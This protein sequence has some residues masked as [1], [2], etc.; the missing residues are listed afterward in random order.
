MSAAIS[1]TTFFSSGPISFSA[2][3]AAFKEVSDG[4]I[5][6]SELRR[7]TDVSNTDPIVPD[8][9]ENNNVSTS[10]DLRLSSF[11]NT[12]KRYNVVQTGTDTGLGNVRNLNWN[13]NGRRNIIKRFI[14]QGTIGTTN[15][16]SPALLFEGTGFNYR[17]EVQGS[18]LGA[19]GAGGTSGSSNG[20][21]GGN[22]IQVVNTNPEMDLPSVTYYHRVI[23]QNGCAVYA[24]GGGGS[25]GQDGGQGTS[26]TC[27]SITEYITER[28]CGSCPGC[29]PG[30]TRISCFN[31][32]GCQ[33][34][35]GGCR[36]RW[37]RAVCQKS[38]PYSVPGAPGGGG[39]TG[40]R[41]QGYNQ[42]RE[43]GFG[44]AA[45][46]PGGCPSY[47]GSG[48][49]GET[50]GNGGDWAITGSTTSRPVGAGQPGRAVTGSR[51]TVEGVINTNTI[52]G[53]Y[54]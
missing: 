14:V 25:Q 18:I 32:G 2:L 46:T 37:E 53:A 15:T 50:G 22:A 54:T 30:D 49:T 33:C 35:K 41:G 9:T 44:G 26:G 7:N 23:L 20:K 51:Y 47:G 28:Q 4:Q 19:G 8:A 11:R 52:R 39:G 48:G 27:F 1:N 24:G 34:G 43:N 3:R 45:G 6:I 21:N 17:I 12:I 36:R 10:T 13:E 5:S 16:A 31:D 42:S 38:T 29:D 40:G